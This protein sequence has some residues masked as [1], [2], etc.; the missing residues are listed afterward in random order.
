MSQELL[1]EITRQMFFTAAMLAAPILLVALV[2]GVMV[3]I[4]QAVTS[5]QEQTLVF[6]PK[7]FAVMVTLFFM[8]PWMFQT[9]VNLTLSLFQHIIT[10]TR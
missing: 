8:L 9:L 1:L 5:I 2:V 4:F 7:M 10:M 3:S 6:I